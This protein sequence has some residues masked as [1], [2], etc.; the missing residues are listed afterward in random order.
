MAL[1]KTVTAWLQGWG[2]G[3]RACYANILQG[4]HK[5]VQSVLHQLCVTLVVTGLSCGLSS[6]LFCLP[7]FMLFLQQRLLPPPHLSSSGPHCN[8]LDY[9]GVP[10]GTIGDD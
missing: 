2:W 8:S 3:R 4:R 7:P 9:Y 10:T 6:L 5:E 1:Y